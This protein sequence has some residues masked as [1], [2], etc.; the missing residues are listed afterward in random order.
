MVGVIWDY[1]IIADSSR[2]AKLSYNKNFAT[3]S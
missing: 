1:Q 2:I 3:W